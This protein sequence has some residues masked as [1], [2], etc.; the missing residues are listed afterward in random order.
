MQAIPILLITLILFLILHPEDGTAEPEDEPP[1]TRSG[2]AGFTGVPYRAFSPPSEYA[3]CEAAHH[4]GLLWFRMQTGSIK[5][6]HAE[7]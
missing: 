6:R 7:F 3:C 1:G 5:T 2:Q 4:I